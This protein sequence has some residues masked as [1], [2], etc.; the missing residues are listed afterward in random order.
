MKI[1]IIINH[2]TGEYECGDKEMTDCEVKS[3]IHSLSNGEFSYAMTG[4]RNNCAEQYYKFSTNVLT[5]SI[6]SY[7][8]ID[9]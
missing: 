5:N 9:K 1:R 7:R 8:I 6:I 2:V 3:L 4:R